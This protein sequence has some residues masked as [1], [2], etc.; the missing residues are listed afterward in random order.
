[1]FANVHL[2]GTIVIVDRNFLSLLGVVS[3]ALVPKIH[4][5]PQG[6]RP[7]WSRTGT[8]TR[9]WRQGHEAEHRPHW[10]RR[11]RMRIEE[12]CI[13]EYLEIAQLHGLHFHNTQYTVPR[14][15]VGWMQSA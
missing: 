7:Q 12:W 14:M 6:Q 11:M 2:S 1:M 15:R 3:Q 5:D 8:E 4:V 13:Y 10:G 9:I